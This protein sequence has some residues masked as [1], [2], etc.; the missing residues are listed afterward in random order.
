MK[1]IV[2]AIL[3]ILFIV[4]LCTAAVNAETVADDQTAPSFRYLD[5]LYK[6]LDQINEEYKEYNID[7][8]PPREFFLTGEHPNEEDGRYYEELYYHEDENG[9]TDWALLHTDL[10]GVNMGEVLQQWDLAGIKISGSS[11]F[12][13]GLPYVVYDVKEDRIRTFESD[14]SAL[15]AEYKDLADVLLKQDLTD[16]TAG[17]YGKGDANGDRSV[18]I[19]DATFIQRKLA[20]LDNDS[21]LVT[22]AADTDEDGEVTVLD[23]TR[24][25]RELADAQ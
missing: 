10:I 3:T 11:L 12:P 1:R 23:A 8:F 17:R 5:A 4:S 15:F 13:F 6:V 14:S 9:D 19:L 2:S 22:F 24:I 7:F 20:Q 18:D 25:Q 21:V 16:I